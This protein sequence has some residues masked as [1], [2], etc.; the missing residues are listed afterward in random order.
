MRSLIVSCGRLCIKNG[1][2]CT[3]T[4]FGL[5]D[6]VS[7]LGRGVSVP[8]SPSVSTPAVGPTELH[9][10]LVKGRITYRFQPK[11]NYRFSCTSSKIFW[12]VALVVGWL[13]GEFVTSLAYG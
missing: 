10:H 3:G 7:I 1:S 8:I 2:L 13:V 11:N 4:G 6:R 5:C 12:V 9:N